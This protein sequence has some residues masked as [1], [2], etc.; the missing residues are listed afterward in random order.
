MLVSC[1]RKPRI[2]LSCRKPLKTAY[3]DVLLEISKFPNTLCGGAFMIRSKYAIV[4]ADMS[5]QIFIIPEPV[6]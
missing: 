2:L 1:K 3:V 5:S 4:I 6:L